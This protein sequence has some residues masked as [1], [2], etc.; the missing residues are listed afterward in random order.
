MTIQQ[1]EYFIE[2]ARTLSFTKTAEIF[3]ISQSAVTQQIKNLEDELGVLL[4]QRKNN[5]I[6]LTPAGQLFAKESKSLLAKTRD[7]ITKVQAVHNGLSGTINIG[8]LKCM[9]MNKFPASIQSFHTKYPSIKINLYRGGLYDLHDMLIDGKLD[10]IINIEDD[11][12]RYPGA[13]SM[14]LRKHGYSVIVPMGHPLAQKSLVEQEDLRNEQLIVHNMHRE[15]SA[16]MDPIPRKFLKDEL[17]GN[18]VSTEN[19]VENIM[20]MV[21]AGMGIAV[22]PNFDVGKIQGNIMLRAIPLNTDGYMA[23]ICEYHMTN[24]SNPLISLFTEEMK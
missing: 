11:N 24:N 16:K 23:T 5:R 2:A 13:D 10:I 20:I 1:L 3:F 12:L 7:V 21:A 14:E 4:F 8:Y 22:L 15:D 18:V 17:L 19:D 9:E 6:T